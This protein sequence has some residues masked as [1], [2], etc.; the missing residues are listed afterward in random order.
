MANTSLGFE[1]LIETT[2][3]P[4]S[5]SGKPA[6]IFFHV[7]PPSTDLYK[8]LV[9]PPELKENGCLL[10]FQKLANN[11]FELVGLMAISAQPVSSSINNILFHDLPPSLE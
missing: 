6:S 1:G 7:F 9:F 8:A 10:N 2:I 11:T 5:P 3:L 4:R